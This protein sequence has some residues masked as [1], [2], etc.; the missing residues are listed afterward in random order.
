MLGQNI[1]KICY[2]LYEI[3]PIFADRQW[4]TQKCVSVSLC[5]L[6]S[7]LCSE[8]LTFLEPLHPVA[9]DKAVVLLIFNT[10]RWKSL[11]WFH[12]V[13]HSLKSPVQRRFKSSA[14]A[15]GSMSAC[16]PRTGRHLCCSVLNQR[17]LIQRKKL[18]VS[19]ETR[20]HVLL[21]QKVNSG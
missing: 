10:P 11:Y 15:T 6:A 13:G 3:L 19:P 20:P 16:S 21:H 8:R 14:G 17:R 7:K 4:P 2:K 12:S 9:H 5:E 1:S 18:T